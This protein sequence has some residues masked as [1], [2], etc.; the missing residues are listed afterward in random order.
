MT[1]RRSH[2][3]GH[4]ARRFRETSD[5]AARSWYRNLSFDVSDL[6]SGR[7][8]SHFVLVCS[9]H[10][11]SGN[12]ERAE[13]LGTLVASGLI[14][15]ESLW[16]VINAGLIVGLS[17]DAPIALVGEHFA[18]APWLG[19]LLFVGLIVLLYGWMLRRTKAVQ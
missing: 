7:R 6:R 8:R 14:V 18:P 4:H 10:S 5:S 9:T 12:P 17:K 16:G 3:V 2:S 15:G 13:R 1:W 11:L 19:L